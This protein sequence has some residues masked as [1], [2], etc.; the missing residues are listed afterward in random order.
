M[1]RNVPTPP[2]A[3][4]TDHDYDPKNDWL[5]RA[6]VV[7]LIVSIVAVFVFAVYMMF[8]YAPAHDCWL[9]GIPPFGFLECAR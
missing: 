8:W 7:L 9:R 4:P 2:K 5:I 6:L 1:G 3:P